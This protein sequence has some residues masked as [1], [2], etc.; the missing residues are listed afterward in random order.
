MSEIKVTQSEK[1][2]EKISL[3]YFLHLSS[4]FKC[5]NSIKIQGI[6]SDETLEVVSRNTTI[7]TLIIAFLVGALSVV[8]AVYFELYYKEAFDDTYSYYIILSIIA[9]MFLFVEI[10]ILYWLSM[11][12][13]YTL[14]S[15]VG[16]EEEKDMP[17]EYDIKK[18]MIRSVLDIEEPIFKYL[19]IDSEK[20][21]SKK[22]ILFTML[23][24]K[25]KKGLTKIILKFLIKRVATR[26]SL[27]VTLYWIAIPIS[28]IWD[29]ISIY[30]VIKGAKLKLFGSKLSKYITEDILT[31]ETLSQYP[32]EMQEACIRVVSTVMVRSKNR[33]P[34]TIILLFRLNQNIDIEEKD[35]Y[36]HLDTFLTYIKNASDREKHLLR[37]LAGISAILDAKM[38][39]KTQ[40]VL[41]KIFGEQQEIYMQFSNDLKA[42]LIT[43]RLHQSAFLCEWMLCYHFDESC[44]ISLAYPSSNKECL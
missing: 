32:I 4:K 33:H 25:V 24:Y 31:K 13:V 23:L 22:M 21:V 42:L 17:S 6:P 38:N 37:C 8:P 26:Y 29:S 30:F 16:Y 11:R 1:Y 41:E 35:D 28:G 10:G 5:S 43:G 12:G 2:I 44:D 19:G 7:N 15:L 18:M 34:N 14:S 20:I 40:E 27:R 9:L 3:K 39:K 36:Q